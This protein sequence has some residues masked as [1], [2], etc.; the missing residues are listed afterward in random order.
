MNPV[1]YYHLILDASGSMSDIRIPTLNAV[2]HQL[3][4]IRKIA[5]LHPDQDIRVSL[6]T[7]NTSTNS[8]FVHR[9]PSHLPELSLKQYKTDGGTALLDAIGIT[10]PETENLL[11]END[12]VIMLIITDGE[13]NASQYFTYQQIA[14]KI[15]ALKKTERWTFSFL[16]AD[17]NA[18]SAAKH[19]HFD[20][21]EV[22]SFS[23]ADMDFTVNETSERLDTFIRFK[24][25]GKRDGFMKDRGSLN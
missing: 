13:E 2:N 20:K 6:T 17:I 19:L 4:S 25:Q 8:A 23:K 18:W 1:T 16:G 10:I 22:L 21:E 24:K 15:Q 9:H 12:D 11:K 5:R 14:R 3:Q 7:F